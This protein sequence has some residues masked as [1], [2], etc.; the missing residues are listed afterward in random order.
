[1][2]ELTIIETSKKDLKNIMELW[3]DGEVMHFVGFPNGIGITV[4]QLNQW[5]LWVNEKGKER[6]HFSI[7]HN[8]IGYCGEAFYDILPNGYVTLDIKLFK[9]ARGKNIAYIAL[10]EVIETAF[11]NGGNIAYVDPHQD[12]QKAF[13][14]YE[15]L[16]FQ[17]TPHPEFYQEDATDV[18]IYMELRKQ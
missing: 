16:G 7:Y 10:K 9:K 13:F 5:L 18:N 15:R 17:K 3:N 14:L 4:E 11:K 2:N 1:M 6:K 8:E 12:N